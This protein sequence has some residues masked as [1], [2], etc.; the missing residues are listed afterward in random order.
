MEEDSQA[1]FRIGD[2]DDLLEVFSEKRRWL[3]NE[4]RDVNH[5]PF[6]QLENGRTV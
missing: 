4:Q 5:R 1:F 6:H 3:F 2:F